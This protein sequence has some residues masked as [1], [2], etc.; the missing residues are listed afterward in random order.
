MSIKMCVKDAYH[1]RGIAEN[2]TTREDTHIVI[3]LEKGYIKEIM[4]IKNV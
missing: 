4:F 1:S 3:H 2:K